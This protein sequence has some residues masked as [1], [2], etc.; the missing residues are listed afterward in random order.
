MDIYIVRQFFEGD[1]DD[2]YVGAFTDFWKAL[3]AAVE[4]Q[5]KNWDEEEYGFM[6]HDSTP[7]VPNFE[8]TQ[9]WCEVTYEG[10]PHG[11]YYTI[12]KMELK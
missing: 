4:H 10:D 11:I 1:N 2:G 5:K 7:Y 9:L 6:V 3:N 12:D 8:V